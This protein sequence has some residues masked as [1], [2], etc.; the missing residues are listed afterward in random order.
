MLDVSIFELKRLVKYFWS[1]HDFIEGLHG[2][3]KGM[4]HSPMLSLGFLIKV[5]KGHEFLTSIG[6]LHWDVSENNIVL[7]LY[8]WEVLHSL[9]F[10][11]I[12]F[13]LPG[14]R[15]PNLTTIIV[16][17]NYYTPYPTQRPWSRH[18]HSLMAVRFTFTSC[19]TLH[20]AYRTASHLGA[21]CISSPLYNPYLASCSSHVFLMIRTR[22]IG[23][24][25]P[26]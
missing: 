4:C 23:Y 22:P 7:G 25:P 14:D 13:A 2:A 15:T 17:T 24:D 1:L 3:I 12:L 10:A 6:I 9:Y 26:I 19:Q 16:T 18:S 11:P 20:H 21:S 5:I 8:P